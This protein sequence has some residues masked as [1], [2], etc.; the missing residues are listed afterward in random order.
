[1]PQREIKRLMSLVNEECIVRYRIQVYYKADFESHDEVATTGSGVEG[2]HAV[3]HPAYFVEEEA[4]LVEAHMPYVTTHHPRVD[5]VEAFLRTLQS[6]R[7]DALM[8]T[9]G[10]YS[11]QLRYALP[12]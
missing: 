8:A 3:F 12:K 7:D 11:L 5:C 4:G 6:D 9:V 2:A 1:M 10:T